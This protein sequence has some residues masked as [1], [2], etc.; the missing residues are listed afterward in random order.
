MLR[1]NHTSRP[2]VYPFG[3]EHRVNEMVNGGSAF[4]ELA[5]RSAIMA[6]DGLG[7]P[8]MESEMRIFVA[9]YDYD[10]ATMSPNPDALQ[11]ELPF[12]EGQ[13]IK[14]CCYQDIFKLNLFLL[15]STS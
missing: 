14:V 5:G 10:P 4:D 8:D 12:R 3:Y 2:G 1:Y 11:E 9:L 6:Q 7:E 13:L 15:T